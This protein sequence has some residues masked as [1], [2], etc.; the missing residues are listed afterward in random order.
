MS[1]AIFHKTVMSILIEGDDLW[2]GS[3][4]FIGQMVLYKKKVLQYK[5]IYDWWEF[6][7]CHFSRDW[8][9]IAN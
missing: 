8:C 6:L 9:A 2:M 4:I 3:S 5:L 1:D 7:Q